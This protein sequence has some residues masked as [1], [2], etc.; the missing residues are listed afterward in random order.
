MKFLSAVLMALCL[1]LSYIPTTNAANDIAPAQQEMQKH[2]RKGPRHHR[3][4]SMAMMK[5]LNLSDAQK[6]KW[7][8]I[9][10]QKKAETAE[11]RKQIKTL[12]EQERKINDK[13][14][15]KIKKL[16]NEEQLK[17][18][19]SMLLQ[20]PEKPHGKHKKFQ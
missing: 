1:S 18:Y 19:E 13:Y 20:R 11:L 3:G 10:E 4:M 15:A 8:E 14:E 7:K 16:L 6:A 5:D 9:S 12:H 17:K 2:I